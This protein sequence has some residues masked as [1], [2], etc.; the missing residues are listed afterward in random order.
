MVATGYLIKYPNDFFIMQQL[1]GHRFLETTVRYVREFSL[2]ASRHAAEFTR[3]TCSHLALI[4]EF[5]PAW[6][7]LDMVQTRATNAA[8]SEKKIE[9]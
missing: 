1:L 6:K 3:A 9:G 7:G 5:K 4:A 8:L 2:E